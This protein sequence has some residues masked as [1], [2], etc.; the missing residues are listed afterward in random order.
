M[1]LFPSVLLQTSIICSYLPL[2]PLSRAESSQSTLTPYRRYPKSLISVCSD[3]LCLLLCLFHGSVGA[4]CGSSS[5]PDEGIMTFSLLFCLWP[6]ESFTSHLPSL[7]PTNRWKDAFKALRSVS[8]IPLEN[9]NCR[10]GAQCS[11]QA[12][13]AMLF[14]SITL[15]L[16]AGDADLTFHCPV[17]HHQGIVCNPSVWALGQTA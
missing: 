3:F 15:Q 5:A 10:H 6:S 9:S 13:S 7:T 1:S 12:A 4:S 16:W 11:A 2:H 8:K 14:M 17:M